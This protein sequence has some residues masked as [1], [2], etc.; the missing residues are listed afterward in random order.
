M[1]ARLVDAGDQQADAVWPLAV[2]LRVGLRAVG[3]GVDGAGD[4]EGAPV[5]Q[6]RGEGLRFQEVGEHAGVGGEAREADADVGVDGD[7]LL[8]VGGEFFGVAL[9]RRG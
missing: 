8:L 9:W 5:G 1:R 3:D 2:V 7:D 6:A 4:G